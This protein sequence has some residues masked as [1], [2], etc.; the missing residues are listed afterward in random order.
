[1]SRRVYAFGIAVAK[2]SQIH[3]WT[4]AGWPL[5]AVHITIFYYF[6][7]YLLF[8]R[9]LLHNFYELGNYLRKGI[10]I[11]ILTPNKTFYKLLFSLVSGFLAGCVNNHQRRKRVL[12][13][14]GLDSVLAEFNKPS[15]S[16]RCVGN[17]TFY[18]VYKPALEGT[19][20]IVQSGSVI[21]KFESNS[22]DFSKDTRKA[23]E[24]IDKNSN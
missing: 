3:S 2:E 14:I 6:G 21:R 20:Y 17:K 5:A 10:M 16:T 9:I 24:Y 1:M 18:D 11:R 4:L 12:K 7:R 19:R 8:Y 15:S 22:T 13:S 23:Y